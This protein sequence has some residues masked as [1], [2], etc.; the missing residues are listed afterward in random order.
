MPAAALGRVP[1]RLRAIAKDGRVVAIASVVNVAVRVV[2]LQRLVG[3]LTADARELAV[4]RDVEVA[5]DIDRVL[6]RLDPVVKKTCLKRCL[7]LYHYL[8]GQGAN[9]QLVVGVKKEGPELKAH[10]WL[11]IDGVVFGDDP[12][13]EDDF[14]VILRAP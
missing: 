9:V 12:R 14:R 4:R 6:D 2:N 5:R 3:W 13:V 11:T 8:S 1:R 10:S 7:V